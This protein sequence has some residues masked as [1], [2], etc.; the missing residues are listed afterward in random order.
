[1][2]F[3][4]RE[5]KYT[6]AS[7]NGNVEVSGYVVEVEVTVR[8]LL[9]FTKKVWIPYVT[10]QGM[11][12]EAFVFSNKDTAMERLLFQVKCNAIENSI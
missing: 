8:H 9:F 12:H 10:F 5:E 11:K 7:L 1:M 6:T 2:N 3:R 4:I